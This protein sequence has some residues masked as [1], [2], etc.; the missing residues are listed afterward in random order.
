MVK[1]TPTVQA[2]QEAICSH[3]TTSSLERRKVRAR[4][5]KISLLLLCGLFAGFLLL[6]IVFLGYRS[7]IEWVDHTHEVISTVE[8]LQSSLSDAE[9]GQRGY[10]LTADK[11]YLLPYEE[12]ARQSRVLVD[13]VEALTADNPLQQDKVR[14]LRAMTDSRLARMALTLQRADQDGLEQA[15]AM[16]REG[17]GERLMTNIRRLIASMRVEEDVLLARRSRQAALLEA[18]MI[19]YG[20]LFVLAAGWLA[21][22][23][24]RRLER[25]YL[26]ERAEGEAL[27]A[28]LQQNSLLLDEVNH[29]VKNSLQ[30]VAT[31]LRNQALK[32]RDAAVREELLVSCSR[33]TAIA[34]VH[35]RLYG[36][37][38]AYDI[39]DLPD[40]LKSI[41]ES[42]GADTG[43]TEPEIAVAAE[44]PLAVSVETAVPV[45]LIVNELVTNA[46]R[47]AF[48]KGAAGTVTVTITATGNA[49]EIAV[50]DNG[51]GMPDGVGNAQGGGFGLNTV[52]SLTRQLKGQLDV[53]PLAPGTCV[54]LHVPLA[55][56]GRPAPTAGTLHNAR[57]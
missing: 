22:S 45:A 5:A 28:A 36:N 6:A 56:K 2:N 39:V 32:H 54:T 55:S 19:A 18:L 10:L 9:T 42:A 25:D 11:Q 37:G 1:T 15:L 14:V 40:L 33:V 29:R 4:A 50:A 20:L 8:Q 23:T 24:V 27:A 41:A 12:G 47:H 17:V 16:V 49:V 3:K 46:I 52:R 21:H 43:D 51:I 7:A 31:L 48:A 44:G 38:A 30:I 26:A 35:R 57:T 34:E 53:Q 13:R